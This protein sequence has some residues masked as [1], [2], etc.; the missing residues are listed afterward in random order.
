MLGIAITT[1]DRSKHIM[2]LV[3]SIKK[4]DR[5]ED[6]SIFISVDYPPNDKY[7]KGY[8]KILQYLEPSNLTSNMKVFFQEHNLGPYKNGVF[9]SEQA[10]QE[11]DYVIFC[12]DDFVLNTKCIQYYLEVIAKYRLNK[13]VIGFCGSDILTVYNSKL[14]RTNELL[15]VNADIVFC[16]VCSYG[17]C[18]SKSVFSDLN[19]R[20]KS[21]D[22]Y[23]YKYNF[24]WIYKLLM[25]SKYYFC[26]YFT[27]ILRKNQSL[28]HCG[29]EIAPIDLVWN[30][31]ALIEE[32]N[33]VSPCVSYISNY[34]YDGTGVHM[35]KD[36]FIQAQYEKIFEIENV[37]IQKIVSLDRK[38]YYKELDRITK[39]GWIKVIIALMMYGK[40]LIIDNRKEK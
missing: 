38:K 18:F 13:D 11:C 40:Y 36:E 26:N 33:F 4:C 16:P 1:L 22:L 19:Q 35:Q 28:S 32:K 34:G 23:R 5:F 7:K 25:N 30:I 14:L 20:C 6:V 29:D 39:T 31:Y 21:G 27:Q 8:E 9:I 15:N 37:N 12:E 2:N 10:F 3:E 24:R 17:I